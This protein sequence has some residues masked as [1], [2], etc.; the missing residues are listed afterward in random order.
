MIKHQSILLAIE[1]I[2]WTE[3]FPNFESTV[4]RSRVFLIGSL[5][6]LLKSIIVP[7]LLCKWNKGFY[8]WQLAFRRVFISKNHLNNI[9]RTSL[10][11][12]M[13]TKTNIRKCINHNTVFDLNALWFYIATL[14]YLACAFVSL[15][16]DTASFQL[17][18]KLLTAFLSLLFCEV[19]WTWRFPFHEP[20]WV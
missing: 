6:V 20:Q 5:L 7:I 1:N 14:C 19:S 16:S 18:V 3:F 15:M 10:A 17:K 8:V 12:R 9:F 11:I 2:S 4:L 13:W